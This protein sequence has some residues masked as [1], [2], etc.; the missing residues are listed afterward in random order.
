MPWTVEQLS[1][2]MIGLMVSSLFLDLFQSV[3]FTVRM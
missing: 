2:G 3:A 1:V